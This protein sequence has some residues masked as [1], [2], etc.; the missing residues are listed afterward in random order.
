M[1]AR[2]KGKRYE[3][4]LVEY[5][6]QKGWKSKRVPASVVDV[7]ATKGDRIAIFEVK[8]KKNRVKSIQVK[9]LFEWLDLFEAYKQRE[10]V[11]AIYNGSW[12]FMKVSEINDYVVKESN[13][14]P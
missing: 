12:L 14:M 2:S 11:L 9:R 8:Y 13:W 1:S 10:A 7:I 4:K 5:L 3:R 6:K